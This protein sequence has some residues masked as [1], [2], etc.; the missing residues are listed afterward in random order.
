MVHFVHFKI[1]FIG[2]SVYN[3]FALRQ[4]LNWSSLKNTFFEEEKDGCKRSENEKDENKEAANI[5]SRN[6]MLRSENAEQ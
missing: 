5:F 3:V 6:F 2:Y 1:W 4:Q